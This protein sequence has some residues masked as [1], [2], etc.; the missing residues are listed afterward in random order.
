MRGSFYLRAIGGGIEF[1]ETS[2]TAHR[3]EFREEF[4]VELGAAQLRGVVENIFE[5]EGSLGHEI[6]HVF[7]IESADI[8]SIAL[9]SDLHD[10]DEGRLVHHLA[11]GP[12][13]VPGRFCI[14]LARL[15]REYPVIVMP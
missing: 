6:V 2:E 8:D 13:P 4:E 10:L 3:R 9:D 12:S 15:G 5:Y 11:H 1:G 14:T 7:G